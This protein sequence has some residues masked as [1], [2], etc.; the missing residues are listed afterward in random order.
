MLRRLK[1]TISFNM[2]RVKSTGSDIE[3][4][5][6]SALWKAGLKGYRKNKKEV[7]GKPDF[8]WEGYKV[9]VFCDSS[10]WHGHKKMSTK[11]HNFKRR[12]RFWHNKIKRNIE[13][14]KEVNK[15]LRAE[16]WSILRFWD[17]QI[18]KDRERCVEKIWKTIRKKC[19]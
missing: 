6:S 19:A 12:K 18:K 10:F 5:L 3:K 13:R 11:L 8:V 1:E 17:F 9:A 15:T 7:F 14:D 4:R 2:S 16:G